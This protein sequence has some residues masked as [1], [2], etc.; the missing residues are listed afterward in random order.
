MSRPGILIA[1]PQMRDGNFAGTVVLLWHYDSEGAMGA[2]INQATRIS[3][4]DVCEQLGL[5]SSSDAETRAVLMGGPVE[6]NTGFVVYQGTAPDAAGW[7]PSSSV[8]VTTSIERLEELI[9]RDAPYLLLLGYAG[10]APGQLDQEIETG[11]WLYTEITD[12]LVFDQPLEE[13]YEHA[14]A[15][16]GLRSHMV[17]MQPI[18][19]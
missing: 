19:E 5:D 9:Q 15:S 3:V 18:D 8:A 10:W 4:S 16:L 12:D 11:S 13:R 6:Q 1:S 17:W 14:L 7:N 2:V